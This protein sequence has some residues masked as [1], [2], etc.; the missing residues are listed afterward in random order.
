MPGGEVT[1]F[2]HVALR[3]RPRPCAEIAQ[4]LQDVARAISAILGTSERSA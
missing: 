4:E 3:I 2:I 1:Q